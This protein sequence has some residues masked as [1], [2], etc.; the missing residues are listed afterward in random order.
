MVY[1]L[2]HQNRSIAKKIQ[3]IQQAA[4]RVEAELIGF[5][6]IPQLAET[7]EEIQNSTETF[8]GYS[9][10]QLQGVISYKLEE[11]VVDIY[12]LVVD[13][14][15]FRKGVG[16]K[17]LNYLLKKQYACDFIVSTGS[18]NKPAMAL[19]KW[20]GFQEGAVVEVAPGIYCIQLHLRK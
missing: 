2:D 6:K 19:Y 8:L 1:Q 17:L 5:Y 18:A 3:Q 11:D 15:H 14:I 13:P 7:I 9:E 4:Y 16:K 20:F 12:R 10:E